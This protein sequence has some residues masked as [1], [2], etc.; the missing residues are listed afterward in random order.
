MTRV[1]ICGVTNVEDACLAAELGAV[2][3][4]LVFWPGSPR[5]VELAQ[6]RAI[7]A[8]LPPFV[9]AVGVF[10]NQVEEALRVVKQFGI[11]AGACGAG[12][13]DGCHAIALRGDRAFVRLGAYL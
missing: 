3:I 11:S 6:A 8:A 9:S 2:A 5:F 13:T 10:V 12:D 4:G 7:V 1:K